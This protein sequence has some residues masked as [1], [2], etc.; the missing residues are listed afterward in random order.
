MPFICKVLKSNIFVW[1][2]RV[3]WMSRIIK[4]FVL[5]CMCW[6]LRFS[7]YLLILIFFL[8]NKYLSVIFCSEFPFLMLLM[9]KNIDLQIVKKSLFCSACVESWDFLW[10]YFFL[11]GV[12]DLQIKFMLNNFFPVLIKSCVLLFFLQFVVVSFPFLHLSKFN[13]KIQSTS[14]SKH[15]LL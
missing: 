4:K 7:L 9:W 12:I 8:N 2:E 11:V 10:C 14:L 1:S 13:V 3:V 5:V 6:E 15:V